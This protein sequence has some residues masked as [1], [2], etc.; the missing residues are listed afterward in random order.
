MLQQMDP[1]ESRCTYGP[2]KGELWREIY[3]FEL[4]RN[5]PEYVD[6]CILFPTLT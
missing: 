6:A 1:N 3:Q 5:Y 2:L 4:W